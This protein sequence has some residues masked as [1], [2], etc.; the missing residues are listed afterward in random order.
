[1]R[2]KHNLQ[3]WMKKNKTNI[4]VFGIFFIFATVMTWPFAVHPFSTIVAAPIGDVFN[5]VTKFEVIKNEGLN[6]FID[7]IATSIAVPDGIRFNV[8]V[9]RVSFFSTAF[10]W[11]FT[12]LVSS[13]FAH[14]L[15][16]FTAYLLSGFSMYLLVSRFSNPPT[17]VFTRA[18]RLYSFLFL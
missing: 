1:M 2:V 12:I 9:D 11:F 10:L 4:R 18:L 3:V 7:G 14:G 15:L 16:V 13:L 6:P 8:G 5:S 17:L